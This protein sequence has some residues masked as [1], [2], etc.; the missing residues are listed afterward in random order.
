MPKEKEE[1]AFSLSLTYVTALE[2][3]HEDHPVQPH[4]E[5]QRQHVGEE[6]AEQGRQQTTDG[7]VD[8]EEV[9]DPVEYSP[10]VGRKLIL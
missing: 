5:E 7:V 2:A 8:E 6:D 4:H 9:R 10:K 1:S 3:A